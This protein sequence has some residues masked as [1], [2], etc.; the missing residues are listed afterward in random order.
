MSGLPDI[1][2]VMGVYNGADR[3]RDTMES[4]PLAGGRLARIHCY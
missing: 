3:L 2:I 1:S 4:R